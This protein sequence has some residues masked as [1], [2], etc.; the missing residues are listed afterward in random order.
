MNDQKV[1]LG[2]NLHHPD[3]SCALVVDGELRYAVAE[4]RLGRRLRHT[5][6]PPINAI[7][8]CL[9]ECGYTLADVD[10]IAVPR[11]PNAN[12]FSKIAFSLRNPIR[13]GNRI[14]RFFLRNKSATDFFVELPDLL[15]MDREDV[16]YK[17]IKVEHHLCHIASAYYSSNFQDE[18]AGISYDASGDFVSMMVARCKGNR[19]EIID[20]VA[21]P[22]SL[23]FFYTGICQFIGFDHF[24]EEYKVMGLAP[25]GEDRYREIMLDI[26]REDDRKWFCLNTQFINV[27]DK[28]TVISLD[29]NQQI[30]VP[31]LYTE[32][33]RDIFG[34]PRDRNNEITQREK[35]LARS[36]QE[37][38]EEVAI[39]CVNKLHRQV[40][41]RNLVMAGGAALNGVANTRILRDTPFRN[42][43]L[44][45]ASSDDGTSLGA[46]FW[47]YHNILQG[48]KRFY[49]QHA[50][51]GP[52]H[53]DE[54]ILE[55]IKKNQC[56]Y[57][58]FSDEDLI[59][60]VAEMIKEG[61]VVGWYQGRSEWGPRALGNRS[62]LANPGHPDMRAIINN[63]IKR[64]ESFRPFAPSVL[65]EYVSEVFEQDIKSPFMMHVVKIREE[66]RVRIPA[67]THVDGTGRLQ[68][69]SEDNNGRYYALIKK[70]HELTGIPLLLNTSYNENEPIVDTPEQALDCFLRTDMDA[71]CLG[72]YILI[73]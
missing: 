14:K 9:K 60:K 11:N 56:E 13:S 61:K 46:A 64:R 59:D 29:E 71:L 53:T 18:T 19:I 23:G 38:F 52:N 69:V 67:V 42:V 37:R 48:E 7:K 62:I 12:L 58:R 30:N 4:E 40:E 57:E 41:T 39:H 24:G 54:E 2:V 34:E 45:C 20:R 28:G 55:A 32:R 6:E 70:F 47:V 10:Y 33:L 43:Y 5:P 73:K 36:C 17:V 26:L 25:Y 16:H 31:K 1:I 27:P 68:S 49:M 72:N 44:Q 21:L 8:T 3:S 50:F 65:E 35:D 63:K 66:W 15:G 22:H 51:W